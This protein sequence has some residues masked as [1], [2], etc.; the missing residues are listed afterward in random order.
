MLLRPEDVAAA[1]LQ[2]L[3]LLSGDNIKKAPRMLLRQDFNILFYFQVTISRKL[4]GCCLGKTSVS[5]TV[6]MIT[7][8]SCHPNSLWLHSSSSQLVSIIRRNRYC[9]GLMIFKGGQINLFLHKNQCCGCLLELP[10][11]KGNS[12]KH[13]QHRFLL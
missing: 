11:C 13:P 7:A 12:N 8:I 1:R 2:Y 4:R 10:F 5:S 6:L 3:V 9:A